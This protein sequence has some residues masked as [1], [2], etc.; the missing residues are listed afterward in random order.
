MKTLN[1]VT[2][3]LTAAGLAVASSA[4]SVAPANAFTLNFDGGFGFTNSEATGATAALEFN[5]IQEGDDVRLDLAIDNTTD[6]VSS[7]FEDRTTS[8]ANQATFMGFAFD[9]LDS[10]SVKDFTGSSYFGNWSQNTDLNPFD[11]FDVA[12]HKNSKLTGGNPNGGLA[13]GESTSV[14]FLFDTALSA[15]DVESGFESGFLDGSLASGARFQEVGGEDGYEGATSEKVKGGIYTAEAPEPEEPVVEEPEEPEEPVVEEPEESEEPV[16]EEPEE[17]EE[18]VVEE[19]E[20][21]VETASVPEPSTLVGLGLAF[22]TMFGV[23]RR[24]DNG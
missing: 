8:G 18:P 4:F 3:T 23:R 6:D 9:L 11:P 2:S 7:V 24:R 19:P 10:V 1:L 5:F 22:G 12:V 16:V 20:E 14:S 15:V 17:P 13:A 21:P